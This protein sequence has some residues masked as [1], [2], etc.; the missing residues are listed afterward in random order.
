MPRGTA[1]PITEQTVMQNAGITDAEMERRKQYVALGPDDLARLAAAK[2]VIAKHV[3]ELT[4]TFFKHLSGI[5]EAKVL[6]GYP[7]LTRQARE[8]KRAHLLEMVDGT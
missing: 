8:L 3:D 2:P 1:Q 4:E 5:P 7:E 6:L